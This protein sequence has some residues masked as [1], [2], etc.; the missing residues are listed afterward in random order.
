MLTNAECNNGDNYIIAMICHDIFEIYLLCEGDWHTFLF[1]VY[2][3]LN[4]QEIVSLSPVLMFICDGRKASCFTI[5]NSLIFI[6]KM[7][8]LGAFYFILFCLLYLIIFLSILQLDFKDLK[9]HGKWL[10]IQ[11]FQNLTLWVYIAENI[12]SKNE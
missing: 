3:T 9:L 6:P 5:F 8:L 11:M 1:H 7:G 12:R 2:V 4:L 10:N